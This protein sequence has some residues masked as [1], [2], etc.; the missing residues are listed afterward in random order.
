MK[1]MDYPAPPMI[2]ALVLG[3]TLENSLRQTLILSQG[4]MAII[5]TRPVSACLMAVALTSIAWIT[6]KSI[7]GNNQEQTIAQ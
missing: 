1:K 3:N 6:Y 7:R 4:S 5:F 2:L